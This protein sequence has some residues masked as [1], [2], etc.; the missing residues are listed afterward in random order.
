[1]TLK[2]IFLD[3]TSPRLQCLINTSTLFSRYMKANKAKTQKIIFIFPQT[4]PVE[5]RSSQTFPIP[6]IGVVI[7]LPFCSDKSMSHDSS[8][9]APIPSG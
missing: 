3:E 9:L 2:F 6:G 4:A 1:M 7:Y 5:I 8:H